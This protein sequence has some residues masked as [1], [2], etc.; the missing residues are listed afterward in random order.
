MTGI[1]LSCWDRWFSLKNVIELIRL[2]R[3]SGLDTTADRQCAFQLLCELRMLAWADLMP[4]ELLAE[5][6]A[7]V[8]V[9]LDPQVV[10]VPQ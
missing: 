9:K 8:G 7:S 6:D 2:K 4:A 3:S 1:E 10:T 5:Y